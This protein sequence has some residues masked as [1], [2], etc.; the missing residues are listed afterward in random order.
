M[1]VAEM[2]RRSRLVTTATVAEEAAA[3]LAGTE[4]ARLPDGYVAPRTPLE[5]QLC[6]VWSGVLGVDR[7]G[8]DDDFFAIG[9]NSLVA[10]QLIA[11]VR[12]AVGVRLPMRTLFETPTVAGLATRVEQL[13]LEEGSAPEPESAAIPKVSRTTPAG[14]R[15]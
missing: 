11:Q 2:V 9:G 1:T 6:E 4:G 15:R 8:V 10:V 12:K 7:I 14:E 3:D 13:R 5:A